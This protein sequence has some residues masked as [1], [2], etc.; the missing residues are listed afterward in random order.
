MFLGSTWEIFAMLGGSLGA[1]WLFI[2]NSIEVPC[3]FY[4]KLLLNSSGAGAVFEFL[5]SS[6]EV[7]G[8]KCLESCFI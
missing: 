5:G 4:H 3:E 8:L 6:F 1:Y 2:G 7:L